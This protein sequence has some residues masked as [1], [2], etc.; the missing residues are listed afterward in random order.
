MGG[1]AGRTRRGFG[2]LKVIPG[3]ESDFWTNLSP[4]TCHSF[5]AKEDSQ[6]DFC[7]DGH[8][9][10]T[11]YRGNTIGTRSDSPS[12]ETEESIHFKKEFV[13]WH[14]SWYGWVWR[15]DWKTWYSWVSFQSIFR[16]FVYLLLFTGLPST[17]A[18]SVVLLD[19]AWPSPRRIV[20]WSILE[21]LMLLLTLS[22]VWQKR[23][24]EQLKIILK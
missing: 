3:L 23:T 7:R 17:N 10:R 13:I 21:L 14:R 5:R 6:W 4:R 11:Q 15:C 9:A 16:S 20:S 12:Q 24:L 19:L 2:S 8:R 18:G 1:L 22:E